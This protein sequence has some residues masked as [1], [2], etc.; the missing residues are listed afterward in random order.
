MN[1]MRILGFFM[2]LLV[3]AVSSLAAPIISGTIPSQTKAEDSAAW[4]LNLTDYESGDAGETNTQLIWSVSEVN[5]SLIGISIDP[6][7]DIVTFT[8]V[9]D[10]NGFNTVNFTLTNGTETASQNVLITLTSVN[11]A[12]VISTISTQ[13][14]QED[15]SWTYQVSASDVDGDTLTYNLVTAPTGMEISSTGLIGWT[16]GS[17]GKEVVTVKVTD[18]TGAS[19][20]ETF[21]ILVGPNLCDGSQVGQI[22]ISNFDIEDEDDDF[23]PG[24]KVNVE[25]NIDN[26]YSSGDE[27]GDVEDIIVE[28]FLYD[29]EGGDELD[30]TESDSFD[31]DAGED[32]D[33][34]E[35]EL[36]LPSDVEDS[37]EIRVYALVYEDGNKDVNCRF[38]SKEIDVKRKKHDVDIDKFTLS[39]S[40]VNPGDTVNVKVKVENIGARGE[41]GV[42]V[43]VR[44]T[45]LGIDETSNEFDLDRYGK[46]DSDHKLTF[47]FIVPDDAKAGTYQIEVNVYDE[48]GDVYDSGS[49]FKDLVVSSTG[50]E[51]AEEKADIGLVTSLAILTFDGTINEGESISIPVKIANNGVSAIQYTLEVVNIDDWAEPVSAKTVN[52][53]A[54]Q[55]TTEYMYLKAKEGVT[56]KHSATINVKSGN[57]IVSTQTALVEVVSEEEREGLFGKVK[58]LFSSTTFL[59]IVG[60]IVLILLAI[61]FIK[62]L[63]TK[64]H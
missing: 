2:F 32:E 22:K 35:L 17:T 33:D 30:N 16:P 15:L 41:D 49:E 25:I 39:P 37:H 61:L 62:M 21:S 57:E 64:K 46:S 28:L 44:N 24:D 18:T 1:K 55:S 4:T 3:F 60:D 40:V 13:E 63:F 27:E 6:T 53:G 14:I 11:D 51:K 5:T 43:K 20:N 47:T 7:T 12:P 54:G 56:G 23:Y 19:D 34:I 52:V 58:N 36:E 31:L 42:T 29:I 9:A 38:E 8:P 10:A 45:A 26:E 48:E 50:V 59:W